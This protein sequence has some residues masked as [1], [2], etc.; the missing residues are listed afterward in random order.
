MSKS[1]YSRPTIQAPTTATLEVCEALEA[2]LVTH[3]AKHIKLDSLL[4]N[5]KGCYAMIINSTINKVSL[6]TTVGTAN[7]KLLTENVLTAIMA[8]YT[9]ITIK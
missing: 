8:K 5:R 6:E 9:T 4:A 3:Y 7:G 2:K 1:N